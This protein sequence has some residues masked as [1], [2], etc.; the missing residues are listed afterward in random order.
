VNINRLIVRCAETTVFFR[1]NYEWVPN[2]VEKNAGFRI[3]NRI[4]KAPYKKGD[5]MRATLEISKMTESG[6]P[7]DRRERPPASR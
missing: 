7:L 6:V 5:L 1:D 2:F 3:E 4:E